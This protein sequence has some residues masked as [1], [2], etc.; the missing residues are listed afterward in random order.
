[1]I[2]GPG[3]ALSVAKKTLGIRLDPY[4]AYNFLVEID[5]IIAGGFTD[6]SGL[7]IQTE[8]E[9]V[10]EGGQNGFQ[11][12]LPKGT[13][14]TD[15]TL[16]QGITDLDLIW[17]WYEDVI[18][19]KIKRKNGSIFM[20]D[21][22][23]LPA[24]WWDFVDAYPVKWDGPMFNASSTTIATQTLVLTHHGLLNPKASKMLAAVRGAASLL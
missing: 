4:S 18:N 15:I 13:T 21:H 17:N 10:T 3:A 11:H 20:L 24:R 6:V 16:K 9:S 8:V 5:G 14:Y 12:K 2:I 1:M 23:G 19:G 7:S 22:S